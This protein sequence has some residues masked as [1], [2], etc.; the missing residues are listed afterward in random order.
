MKALARRVTLTRHLLP[1][2]GLFTLVFV[3]GLIGLEL[4]GRYTHNDIHDLFA[5]MALMVLGMS[6]LVRHRQSPL[7][8]LRKILNWGQSVVSLLSGLRYEH[9]VDLRGTPPLPRRTPRVVGAVLL[10]LLAWGAASTALWAF[11]PQGWRSLGVHTLYILYLPVLLTLWCSLLAFLCIGI[12]IPIAVLDRWLKSWLGETDRRGAIVAAVVLYALAVSGVASIVPASAVLFLCLVV[13]V[14]SAAIYL[15]RGSDGA[16]FL[17]RARAERPIYAVP[18][19]RV[20]AAAFGLVALLLF[21]ILMM[22]CGGRLFGAAPEADTMPITSVLGAMTAWT[23]PLLIG[24]GV[25]WLANAHRH[26]PARRSA[27]T[28]RIHG[29]FP[30]EQ[31]RTTA[32]TLARWGW[33]SRPAANGRERGDVG[34]EL[35][36]PERSEATEFDPRWPLKVS[37]ADLQ[38]GEVRSRLE[39]RDE[40]QLRRHFF[41]G[42]SKL[43]KRAAPFKGPGGGGL[44]LAPQWWFI[45][46]L[47]REDSDTAADD[48]S[49]AKL[50]GPPY[51]RVFLPRA[52]QH[53]HQVLRATAVDMIFIEDGVSARKVEKVLRVLLELFDVHGGRE[54]AEEM[55]FRGLPKV[56]VMIHDYE[57][58]NPFESD[59]YPEPKFDDLSR[60]RVLHIF[61]DRGGHEERVEPPADFSWTPSPVGVMG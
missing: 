11:F 44:W 52:R 61:R 54:R 7:P 50:V 12:F 36:H 10:A 18:L 37:L 59:V 42:L 9:G 4:L 53:L 38:A 24:V 6:V 17:W 43:F 33:K 41:R 3:V 57:P 47:G 60:V 1:A 55:H 13:A 35:V 45:E 51:H 49:S 27:P 22:A 19:R 23:M 58:G 46:G 31:M 5:S 20:L 28:A 40:I 29:N 21:N 14:A 34:I 56:R 30:P 48:P 26:D 32:R 16:A 15:P 8:W 2:R 39:R 25:F